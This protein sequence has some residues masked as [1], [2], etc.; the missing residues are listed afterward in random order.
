MLAQP[1]DLKDTCDH[2]GC[3]YDWIVP[4]AEEDD[5]IESLTG[6]G[7]SCFGTRHLPRDKEQLQRLCNSTELVD[8]PAYRRQR[9]F[10]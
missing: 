3:G 6:A 10:I 9:K 1:V 7:E 5:L 8:R 2:A 4:D